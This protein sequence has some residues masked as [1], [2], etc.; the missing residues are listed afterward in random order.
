MK[1]RFRVNLILIF[2]KFCEEVTFR[3]NVSRFTVMRSIKNGRLFYGIEDT[4]SILFKMNLAQ[5]IRGRI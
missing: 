2:F 1:L 3:S 4:G 5:K